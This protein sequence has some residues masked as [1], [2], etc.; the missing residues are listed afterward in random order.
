MTGALRVLIACQAYGLDEL[1]LDEPLVSP[2]VPLPLVLPLGLVAEL[3]GA[4]AGA[5][6]GAGVIVLVPEED[7]AAP[8]APAGP[9]GPGGPCGPG[10]GVCNC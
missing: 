3:E 8:G 5:G 1:E 7:P 4:E 9:G 10:I 6:V 2:E